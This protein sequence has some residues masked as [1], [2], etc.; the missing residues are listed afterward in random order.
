M[1]L[2]LAPSGFGFHFLG[3]KP[4]VYIGSVEFDVFRTEPDIGWA[5]AAGNVFV[6]SAFRVTQVYRPDPQLT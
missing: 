1:S 6:D 3:F 4:C 5:V 2:F